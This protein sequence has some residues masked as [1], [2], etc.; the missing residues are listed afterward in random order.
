MKLLPLLA[1]VACGGPHDFVGSDASSDAPWFEDVHLG[2]SGGACGQYVTET[3]DPGP[4]GVLGTNDDVLR[5]GREVQIVTPYAQISVVTRDTTYAAGDVIVRDVR[6]VSTSATTYDQLT[7]DG[8]GADGTWGT[9]DDHV[10]ARSSGTG[11]V[12]TPSAVY[13]YV[14][15][16]PDNVWST[17]DDVLSGWS[18][19]VYGDGTS[20]PF[21]QQWQYT[22]AGTA[23]L[24]IV[25]SR[26]TGWGMFSTGAGPDGTWGTKDDVTDGRYTDERNTNGRFQTLT[27]YGANDVVISLGT[28]TC[29]A[30]VY[31]GRIMSGAGVVQ[32]RIRTT[33]CGS[34]DDLPK[35]PVAPN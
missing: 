19:F 6:V 29:D 17:S 14:S 25:T 24:G 33:A 23:N 15:P 7:F 2:D 28:I 30:G 27:M 32:T 18:K 12:I 31:D 3:Y 16:G 22:S 20:A 35:S 34:C 13:D 9:D 8:P 10:A 4:D 1:L 11:P 5:P 26:F 21:L